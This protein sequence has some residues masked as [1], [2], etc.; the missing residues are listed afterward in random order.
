AQAAL[1]SAWGTST[2][3]TT[4]NNYFGIK[5]SYN[6]ASV[7]MK[8]AEY[9]SNGQLYYTNA[10]FRKYPSAKASMTDNAKLL[11]NGT[12]YNTSIYSGTWRENAATYADAANALTGTYATSPTYGSSLISIIK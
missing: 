2:L 9:D 8:T 12:S 4:A 1:E 7:T 6:G 11:R 3:T 10:N 5:G